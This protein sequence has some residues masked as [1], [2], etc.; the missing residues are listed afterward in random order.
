MHVFGQN[1]LWEMP[2]LVSGS[3]PQHHLFDQRKSF[4][5]GHGS[6]SGQTV[7]ESLSGKQFHGQECC[8]AGWSYMIFQVKDPADVR[9]RHLARQVYLAFKAIQHF[10]PGGDLGPDQLQ[11]DSRVQLDV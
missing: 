10:R 8:P 2:R 1:R 4:V 6:R 11:G 7:G 9:V 5:C 3:Q